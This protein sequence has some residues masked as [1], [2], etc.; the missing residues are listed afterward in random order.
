MA[1]RGCFMPENIGDLWVTCVAGTSFIKGTMSTSPP[2]PRACRLLS[3]AQLRRAGVSCW[4]IWYVLR[5]QEGLNLAR[6]CSAD[7]DDR[8]RARRELRAAAA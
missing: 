4:R 8:R 6:I 3:R 1:I 7:G 2:D 5:I